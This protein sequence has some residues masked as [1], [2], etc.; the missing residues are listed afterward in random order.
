MK[1]IKIYENNFRNHLDNLQ[2]GESFYI[3]K[4]RYGYFCEVLKKFR[5]TEKRFQ[6]APAIDNKEVMI[7]WRTK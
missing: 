4:E 5:V 6:H 7:T 2:I 3:P 1:E